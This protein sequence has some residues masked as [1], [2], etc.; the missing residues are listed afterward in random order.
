MLNWF[1]KQWVLHPNVSRL[2]KNQNEKAR[3]TKTSK[4]A[5]KKAKTR[6]KKKK[7]TKK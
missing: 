4:A 2:L 3:L 6:K 5:P 7:A 1:K